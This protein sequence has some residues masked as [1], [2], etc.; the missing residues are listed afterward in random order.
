VSAYDGPFDRRSSTAADVPDGY[1]VRL[2]GGDRALA[3][4]IAGQ[5]SRD[6]W[7]AQGP[8]WIAVQP[9]RF[10]TPL[11]SWFTFAE[12]RIR[13]RNGLAALPLADGVVFTDRDGFVATRAAIDRLFADSVT[14]LGAPVENGRFRLTSYAGEVS[15][16]DGAQLA[17]ALGDRWLY[18]V[19]LRMWL[20]WPRDPDGQALL[21][22]N[23]VALADATGASVWAPPVGGAA[24]VVDGELVARDR[25]GAVAAWQVFHPAGGRIGAVTL[26]SDASGRLVVGGSPAPTPSAVEGP[27]PVV[28]R[29]SAGIDLP[30]PLVVNETALEIFVDS[31]WPLSRVEREGLP[32]S[33]R[34]VLSSSSGL[35][36]R[37][38]P[39]G[40]VKD[41]RG[42]L[43]PAGW[44]DRTVL[45]E[46]GRPLVLRSTGASHG[47]DGLPEDVPRLTRALE[48][49][50]RIPASPPSAP[51]PP[52]PDLLP[53][54]RASFDGPGELVRLRLAAGQ[55][56]DIAA[57]AERLSETPLL[58][59]RLPELRLAG[60]E[61][62]VPRSAYAHVAVVAEARRPSAPATLDQLFLPEPIS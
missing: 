7:I 51:P 55:A 59:T 35:K 33:G 24:L 37:V 54:Q 8:A 9:P 32:A 19:D 28:H 46:S 27:A 13:P 22:A 49:F 36:L 29:R 43:V 38:A 18:G 2:L 17:A 21:R 23:L 30:S 42:W 10:A 4:K 26:G 45:V 56:L 61:L 6:V 40:A 31:P 1:D 3:E 5:L 58:R 25:D 14:T 39:G 44:L 12:G 53:V 16:L 34:Y 62:A 57:A 48:V 52:A 15:S 20:S 47:V 41:P 60:V 50:A 11:D